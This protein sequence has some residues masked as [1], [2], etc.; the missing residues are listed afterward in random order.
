MHSPLLAVNSLAKPN[1]CTP[2]GYICNSNGILFFLNEFANNSEF[3]T[4]TASSSK[5]CHK[6]VF[7]VSLDTNSSKDN[8]LLLFSLASSPYKLSI[9]HLLAYSYPFISG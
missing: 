7:G 1:P 5:V 2:L 3:S 9:D 6:N 4:G 8:S